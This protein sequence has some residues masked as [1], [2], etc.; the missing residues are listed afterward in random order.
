[1]GKNNNI[2]S[3]LLG[4]LAVTGVYYFANT[5]KTT[6]YVK[7]V[8]F[9]INDVKVD[10]NIVTITLRIVNANSMPVL[11]SA[12]LGEV[13]VNTRKIGNV[14]SNAKVEIAPTSESLYPIK[15]SLKVVQS[16]N[17]LAELTKNLAGSFLRFTG[18]ANVDRKTMDVD[19]KFT[20]K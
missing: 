16:V 13:F 18:V 4:V 1:M 8:R 2:G 6:R 5:S 10:R 15:V 19:V 3:I 12:V 7:G 11:V 20:F 14:S 17:A 9:F